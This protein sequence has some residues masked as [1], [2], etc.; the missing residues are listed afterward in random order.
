[1]YSNSI[2]VEALPGE[3][4]VL[5]F[6]SVARDDRFTDL[7]RRLSGVEKG[8]RDIAEQLPPL[9][10]SVKELKSASDRANSRI[11]GWPKNWAAVIGIGG[12]FLAL[13]AIA[14]NAI[15]SD[16]AGL[17]SDLSDLR[18]DV[19][20]L[21]AVQSSAKVIKEI[22]VLKHAE[23]ARNL[24]ALRRAMEQPAS[25]A[26]AQP[27]ALRNVAAKLKTTDEATAD[28]WP[29]VLRF[30]QFAS[31]GL[32]ANVPPPGTKANVIVR[33]KLSSVNVGSGGPPGFE[34][35]VAELDGGD[36]EAVYFK[37]CRVRFTQNP[38]RF[39]NVS[40]I[41]CVFEM[42]DT[43]SPTPYLKRASQLLLASGL[44]NVSIKG[45]V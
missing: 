20:E 25:A 13:L 29:T 44:Q 35:C 37:N 45:P 9:A 23:F 5:Y 31:S 38:V 24:P 26:A 41:N 42:P 7:D 40:F 16:F 1:M 39:V 14:V 21:R 2:E 36:L 27:A 10:E 43:A 30:I 33:G 18:A 32:S 34:N 4:D 6:E 19:R 15:F 12:C 8:V 3:R 11:G 17:R 28:Y 22:S